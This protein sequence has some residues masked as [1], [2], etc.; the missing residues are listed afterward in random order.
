MLHC[1]RHL[2]FGRIGSNGHGR[3]HSHQTH[4]PV[5]EHL[6]HDGGVHAGRRPLR[7][8]YHRP[9]RRSAA[10]TL[11]RRSA[12]ATTYIP[13]RTALTAAGYTTVSLAPGTYKLAITTATAVYAFISEV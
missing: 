2:P 7:H 12:D 8:H 1:G 9:P 6:G 11:Q 4:A 10:A 5:L 3:Q 13:V